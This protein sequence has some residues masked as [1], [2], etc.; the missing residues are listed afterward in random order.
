M[1]KKTHEEF[2]SQINTVFDGSLICLGTYVNNSTR[3]TVKCRECDY[4]WDALPTNLTR[5]VTSCKICRA[6]RRTRT[7]EEY[8]R[9]LEIANPNVVAIE[10]YIKVTTAIRHKCLSCDHQWKTQP[11]NLLNSGSGCPKC[12]YEVTRAAKFSHSLE[13]YAEDLAVATNNSIKVVGSYTNNKTKIK[14]QCILC[15]NEWSVR[16]DSI[17]HLGRGCPSCSMSKGE[18]K[19]ESYLI[20][21]SIK[22][23]K[24]VR[25]KKCRLIKPLP[26][27]FGVYEGNNL[28][29]LIEFDGEQ[30]FVSKDFFGGDEGFQKIQERDKAKDDFCKANN[31]NLIRIPYQS[32]DSI[33]S[34]LD[35]KLANLKTAMAGI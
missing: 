5:G 11:S 16:P 14:H 23:R 1:K 12:A 31:L 34:I 10:D 13:Q 3:L 30:H 33:E 7:H 22:F 19:I 28:I 21:Y 24:Q 9:E 15:G 18:K 27:D 4:E 25:F 32:Y 2:I 26:F 6:E 8:V 35:T 29:A 17:L 20:G